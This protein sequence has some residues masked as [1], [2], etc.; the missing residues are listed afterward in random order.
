MKFRSL[1]LVILASLCSWNMGVAEESS[2]RELQI[3]VAYLYHFTKFTEWP[4]VAPIFHYCVYQNA[5][6]ADLL[7]QTYSTKTIGEARI[8]VQN[9]NV[10]TQLDDCQLIY[11]SQAAPADFLEKISKLAILS[12]GTQE[13]FTKSGGIIYLFEE[14]QKMHFHINNAAAIEAGLK[15][16]SQLLNLSREP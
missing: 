10:Q 2:V 4:I 3:K 13:D 6:F 15:I 9:I 11:F 14:D 1:I 5:D 16:S 12:I 7:R 8:D